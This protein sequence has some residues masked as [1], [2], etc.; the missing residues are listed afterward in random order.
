VARPAFCPGWLGAK[1][2]TITIGFKPHFLSPPPPPSPPPV[3][4]KV[5]TPLPHTHTRI[6]LVASLHLGESHVLSF[7]FWILLLI[8]GGIFGIPE[9]LRI[10][11]LFFKIPVVTYII[12]N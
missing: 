9:P 4:Y 11:F 7:E 1:P 8:T 5:I 3:R 2:Q 10:V 12:N 6:F